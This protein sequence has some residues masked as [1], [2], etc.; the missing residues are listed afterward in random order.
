[1]R[2]WENCPKSL[3]KVFIDKRLNRSNLVIDLAIASTTV[4]SWYM[5]L[6]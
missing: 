1:M 3:G 2:H 4:L 5:K 6:Y